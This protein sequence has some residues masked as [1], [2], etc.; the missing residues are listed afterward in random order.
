MRFKLIFL[1]LFWFSG[2]GTSGPEGWDIFSKVVFTAT[3]FEDAD[4]YFEVPTFNP[5]LK[6][7]ENKRIELSGYFIPIEVDTI[8]V[9]SA[10]PYSSCFFCGGGGPETVA[11]VRMKK[12]PTDLSPDGLIKVEGRLRLNEANIDYMNFILEDAQFKE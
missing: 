3:Y 11:E 10:L 1:S 6:A 2:I 7:L 5:E 4:A 9:L 12:V 8:F